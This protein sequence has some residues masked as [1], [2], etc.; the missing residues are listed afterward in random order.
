M[1]LLD[2]HIWVWWV[3]G[4]PRLSSEELAALDRYATADMG[5]SVVS[6]WEVSMLHV[7]GRIELPCLLDEWLDRALAY[8]GVEL[9]ALSRDI[10][11]ASC[12]LPGEL[13]RDPLD[14]MLIASARDRD[15]PLVTA[16]ERI[17]R[18]ASVRSMRP[19]DLT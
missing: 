18:Y 1:I 4:D 6:C 8:P 10:A 17:L 14:R 15:C 19:R 13:H 7:R 12:R 11:V 5:V 2:T 3:Q 16:D 9:I